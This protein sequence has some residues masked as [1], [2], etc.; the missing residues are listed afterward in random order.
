[1]AK[2]IRDQQYKGAI[3]IPEVIGQLET[4]NAIAELTAKCG[5]KADIRL[6]SYPELRFE[7]DVKGRRQVLQEQGGSSSSSTAAR[8]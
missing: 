2:R 4:Q 5:E 1:M 8:W 7:K 3:Q 6:N